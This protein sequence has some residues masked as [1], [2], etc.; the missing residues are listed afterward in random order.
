MNKRIIFVWI[1]DMNYKTAKHTML[2]DLDECIENQVLNH[3][4]LE[5]GVNIKDFKWTD[6]EGSM[7]DIGL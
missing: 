2:A 7:E 5:Y 6:L 3:F 4:G 1:T